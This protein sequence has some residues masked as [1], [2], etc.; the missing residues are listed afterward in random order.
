MSS[1]DPPNPPGKRQR[2][3]TS[4]IG[5]GIIINDINDIDT[6]KQH[7]TDRDRDLHSNNVD[8]DD[9]NN[10]NNNNNIDS[11]K[12][13]S[14]MHNIIKKI[15]RGRLSQTGPHK[16]PYI[17]TPQ[18]RQMEGGNSTDPNDVH[19]EKI[20][21]KA[22]EKD[23]REWEEDKKKKG[24]GDKGKEVRPQLKELKVKA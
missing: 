20:T 7:H 9:D 21:K 24:R 13:L 11:D 17:W 2:H 14:E 19:L 6:T 12:L 22:A 15:H 10:N 23:I 4:P 3:S 16:G 18:T 8:D 1:N 5:D